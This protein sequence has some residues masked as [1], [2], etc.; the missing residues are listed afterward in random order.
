M[1]STC[2]LD[3]ALTLAPSK[4]P[5][6]SSL[7]KANIDERMKECSVLSPRKKDYIINQPS[8]ITYIQLYF[9]FFF[10]KGL[11]V[12]E[13]LLQA[14]GARMWQSLVTS[15]PPPHPNT[16]RQRRARRSERVWFTGHALGRADRRAV[17][18]LAPHLCQHPVPPSGRH[19]F[20][21]GRPP[22]AASERGDLTLSSGTPGPPG[23]PL[24]RRR[25]HERSAH[26]SPHSGSPGS[27][28]VPSRPFRSR[29]LPFS[30]PCSD[31][32]RRGRGR[33][34]GCG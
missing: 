28:P 23:P 13:S 18:F 20:H 14:I 30:P 34:C 1:T 16:P 21:Q 4:P 31:R 27:L 24:H 17:P 15:S 11:Q 5:G 25:G 10:I 3:A 26:A 22:L 33:G 7:I 32:R 9:F 2:S 8:A 6:S 12:E 19:L 29:V